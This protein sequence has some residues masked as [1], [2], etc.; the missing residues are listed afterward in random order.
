[1]DG[2]IQHAEA[3]I[4]HGTSTLKWLNHLFQTAKTGAASEYAKIEETISPL[5][6][7]KMANWIMAVVSRR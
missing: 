4:D 2:A 7:E 5:A 3:W 1:L 6:L